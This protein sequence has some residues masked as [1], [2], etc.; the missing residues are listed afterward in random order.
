MS[1]V[2]GASIAG[3]CAGVF[4]A[5]IGHAQVYF[6][7]RIQSP[8]AEAGSSFGAVIAGGPDGLLVAQPGASYSGLSSVGAAYLYNA[9]NPNSPFEFRPQQAI[10]NAR[11]GSALSAWNNLLIGAPGGSDAPGSARGIVEAWNYV[12]PYSWDRSD[13]LAP[14][15]KVQGTGF[16]NSIAI[17][18]FQALIGFPGRLDGGRISGAAMLYDDDFPTWTYGGGFISAAQD[19]GF[20]TSVAMAGI[21]SFV[22]E[23]G[24]VNG[25][26]AS[27]RIAYYVN[28]QP[29]GVLLSGDGEARDFGGYSIEEFDPYLL[30]G[31]PYPRDANDQALPGRVYVFQRDL[32]FNYEFFDVLTAPD[33]QPGDGFGLSIDTY[34]NEVLVGAPGTMVGGERGAGAAWLFLEIGAKFFPSTRITSTFPV[35]DG[36]FGQS[37]SLA[38]GVDAGAPGEPDGNLQGAG[39]VYRFIVDYDVIFKG[40]FDFN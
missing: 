36:H 15:A 5:S 18:P 10:E 14:P 13:I 24:Y 31:V 8:H 11:Y 7:E 27:G 6:D 21:A 3:L 22:G 34:Q 40:T 25:N 20:G 23:P 30:V 9:G 32:N 26:G 16:G 28:G 17:A 19:L 35:A 2:S 37:V 38:F 39:A 4:F 1:R 33:G 29:A 12:I